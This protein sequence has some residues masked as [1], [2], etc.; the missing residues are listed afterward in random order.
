MTR[1]WRLVDAA[2]TPEGRLE[3]RRRG[4]RDFVI[5]VGGRV[6][7]NGAAS[8]SEEALARAACAGL[9]RPGGRPRVLLGGLGMGLT[10][11]AAL[12]AL[13]AKAR[14]VVAEIDSTIVAWCR[15]PLAPLHGRALD[16]RRVEVRVADV[17]EVIAEVIARAAAETEDG[18]DARFDAII[19]DLYEG[20]RGAAQAADPLYGD[21]ALVRTRR[22]LAPGGV[23]AVWSEEPDAAFE[24]RLAAAGFRAERRRPGGGGPRHAIY[25]GRPMPRAGARGRPA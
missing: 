17:S 2:E 23:L 22:A 6:L 16:D 9:D 5:T 7:M 13:P 4:E 12:D 20:P 8:R 15:G 25:L 24:R 10:L 21:A 1:P 3:L 18:I 19:L 14:V 11:R